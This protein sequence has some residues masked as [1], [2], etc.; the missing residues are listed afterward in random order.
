MWYALSSFRCDSRQRGASF[1]EDCFRLAKTGRRG[2]RTLECL[3][4]GRLAAGH[5]SVFSAVA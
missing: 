3:P 5:R 1:A 4:V 2:P